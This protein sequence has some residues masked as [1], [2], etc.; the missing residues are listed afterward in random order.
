M[1]WLHSASPTPT[2]LEG[3]LGLRPEL[4][5]LY[6]DFYRRLWSETL[7]APRLLELCR[8]R[9]A[10]AHD[11]EAERAIRHATARVT[12]AEVAALGRWRTAECFAPGERA[13]LTIADKMPWA[14]HAVTDDDV[15][16]LRAHLSDREVVA[17]MLA[18]ALFDVQCRLRLALGV[19]AQP[20]TVA[21]PASAAVLY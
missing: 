16:A 15:A 7:V 3:A 14:P 1:S 6:R 5:E 12:D 8:L 20:A 18:L 21:A 10:I 9:I 2:P 4:L 17:F 11:C 19:A 13:A